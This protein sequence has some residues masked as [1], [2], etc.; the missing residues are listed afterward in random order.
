VLKDL[1]LVS[2]E[3]RDLTK[4]VVGI[5]DDLRDSIPKSPDPEDD[6]GMP[7]LEN[8][9]EKGGFGA[10][11]ISQALDLVLDQMKN[12]QSI[13]EQVAMQLNNDQGADEVLLQAMTSVE[14]MHSKLGDD[15][16]LAVAGAE[17]S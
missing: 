14:P 12:L 13:S 8:P 9:M 2:N 1:N 4:A 6:Q 5:C 7:G 17:G 16:A 11:E 15:G 3:M 10:F